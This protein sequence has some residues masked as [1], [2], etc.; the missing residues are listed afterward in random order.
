MNMIALAE[1]TRLRQVAC[2]ASLVEKKWKGKCSKIEQLLELMAELKAG[3]NR[4]LVFSQFTSF[5]K[6]ICQAL[7]EAGEK[8]LYLDGTVPVKKREKLVQEFQEGD[9]PF[10]LISLK[11]GGLG[12]NLTEANYIIHLDHWWNPAIEQQATDRAY[13]IGQTQKVTAY[14]LISSHTIEE[15]IMR[16]HESKR[17]LADALLEGSDMSHKLT[18]HELMDILEEQ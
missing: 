9:C 5:F 10:F 15:K 6:L 4:A 11:A 8:Y 12:L 18:A 17:N 1:I 3:G 13:R 14:H 2:S 16:L 7:D